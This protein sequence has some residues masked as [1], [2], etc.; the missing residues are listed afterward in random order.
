MII[1]PLHNEKLL[2]QQLSVGKQEA[3]TC[4]YKHYYPQV[5]HVVIKFVKH[6]EL[7]DD[8]SQEVFMKIWD[9]H[10]QLAHVQSFQ[11]YLVTTTRN[12]CIDVLKRAS[13]MD[14]VKAEMIRYATELNN[15][16]SDEIITHEYLKQLSAVYESL[17]AQTK[18]VFKLIKG[19]GKSY[20]E[21]AML[22]GVSRSAVNKH[23]VRSN[24]AF[25]NAVKNELGIS[26][27]LLLF[28]LSQK[29]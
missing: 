15:Q 23:L 13:R 9:H 29:N 27:A 2:L 3:F 17:P 20:D 22:L 8:L 21:V 11:A 14:E 6:K 5:C 19:E 7:A 10:L 24:K 28:L 26:L 12:H 18:E 16:T 1:Q 25:Q 4:L